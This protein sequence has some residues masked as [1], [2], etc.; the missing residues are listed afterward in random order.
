MTKKLLGAALTAAFLFPHAVHAAP[1][2]A[3]ARVEAANREAL[4]EPS[5]HGFVGA[6]Q[7]YPYAEGGVYRLI[8]APERVTDIALEPGE[9]LIAVAAGDTARWTVGDTVSGAGA[10][11]RTHIM[12]KPLAP[13]LRTN[14]VITT[15]RRVYHLALES[16]AR[17]AMASVGWTYPADALLAIER[18]AAA[19][20][21]SA[22]VA[23]GLDPAALD[24]SY[25]IRGDDPVW[26]PLRAFDDGRQVY[27]EFPEA[28]ARDVAPPLF[29]VG[30]N[31]AAELVNYRVAGRFYIVDRLFGVAELRQGEKKQTV[32][33]ICSSDRTGKARCK[34]KGK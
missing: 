23:D 13:G 25:V 33:R 12:I 26:R 7:I 22:P 8:A 5:P 17:A 3:S 10:L 31:G 14:L 19:A 20:A 29:V 4:R 18:G 2:S 24:F 21:R 15:D 32:V 11:R 16:G 1:A 28:I 9:E 30:D 27:I 34:G 6:A